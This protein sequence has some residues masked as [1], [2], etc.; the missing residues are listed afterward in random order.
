MVLVSGGTLL[1]GNLAPAAAF[2]AKAVLS[3]ATLA[4]P[5]W[6][7]FLSGAAFHYFIVRGELAHAEQERG[8]YQRAVHYVTHEMRTP[9]TAIQGSSG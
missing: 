2:S 9:L 3:F 7:V 5:T 4:F 1:V 6:F 8:R